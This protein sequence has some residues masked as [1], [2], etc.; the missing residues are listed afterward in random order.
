M[1]LEDGKNCLYV[2]EQLTRNG[3]EWSNRNAIYFV[4][5]VGHIDICECH[6]PLLNCDLSMCLQF[7][8]ARMPK[9]EA[10]CH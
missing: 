2:S 6:I 8:C 3:K 7:C 5:G 9:L 1:V 4:M 10:L